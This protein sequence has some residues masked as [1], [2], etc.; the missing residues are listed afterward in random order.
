MRVTGVLAREPAPKR[1]TPRTG[2]ECT[3]LPTESAESDDAVASDEDDIGDPHH[4]LGEAPPLAAE[5][6]PAGI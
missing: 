2:E 3:K 4:L 6:T 5:P 1:A